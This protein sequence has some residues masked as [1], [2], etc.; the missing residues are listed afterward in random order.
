MRVIAA[1]DTA[2][3]A[4]QLLQQRDVR[5]R[6]DLEAISF[7][8]GVARGMQ[9]GCNDMRAIACAFDQAATLAR[10]SGPRLLRDLSAQIIRENQRCNHF[11][12]LIWLTSAPLSVSKMSISLPVGVATVS[13]MRSLLVICVERMRECGGS[14]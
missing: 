2:I 10:E 14:A 4:A 13:T 5:G 12:F 1:D 11:G 9:R 8:R 7:R 3:G 6:V